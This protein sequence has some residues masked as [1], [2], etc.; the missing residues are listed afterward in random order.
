MGDIVQQN[1]QAMLTFKTTPPLSAQDLT[2]IGGR[3]NAQH[4]VQIAADSTR[5]E[6]VWQTLAQKGYQIEFFSFGHGSLESFY[7]DF[8]KQQA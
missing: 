2:A 3:L 1:G 4:A 5:A 7:L 8:L 6:A